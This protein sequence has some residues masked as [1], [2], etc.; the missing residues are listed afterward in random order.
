MRTLITVIIVSLAI[1]LAITGLPVRAAVTYTIPRVAGVH[2][3]PGLAQ[4]DPRS[5][6]SFGRSCMSLPLPSP[7][8]APIEK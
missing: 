8:E 4:L 1:S 3:W 2:L 7:A 5:P 6:L